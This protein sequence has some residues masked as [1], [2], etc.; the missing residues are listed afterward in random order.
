MVNLQ[1][2]S[3]QTDMADKSGFNAPRDDL[4]LP[5]HFTVWLC[6]PEATFLKGK[7]VWAN[8]DVEELKA[9]SELIAGSHELE[10]GL[11]GVVPY[12]LGR[13]LPVAD[14]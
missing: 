8:W 1:P 4:D 12:D 13:G 9:K 3:I 5:G 14:A 2:G 10:V 6:S 11:N 7:Y